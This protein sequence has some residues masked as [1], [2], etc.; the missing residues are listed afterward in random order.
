MGCG[1]NGGTGEKELKGRKEIE[2]R[3]TVPALALAL[4]SLWPILSQYSVFAGVDGGEFL[5]CL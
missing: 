3:L 4:K 1:G 2:A 5:E